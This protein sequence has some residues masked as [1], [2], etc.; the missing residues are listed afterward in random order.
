MQFMLAILARSP[1]RVAEG[2]SKAC[3]SPFAGEAAQGMR[4]ARLPCSEDYGMAF[5]FLPT[6]PPPRRL[7]P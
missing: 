1:I 3:A 4:E 7:R 2:L 5:D 6:R